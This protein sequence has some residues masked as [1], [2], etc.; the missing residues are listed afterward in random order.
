MRRLSILTFTL[1][2]AGCATS[3]E[4]VRS[5]EGHPVILSGTLSGAVCKAFYKRGPGA[6]KWEAELRRKI[7]RTPA[8]PNMRFSRDACPVRG[9]VAQCQERRPGGF[10]LN[11]LYNAAI[12]SQFRAT[13]LARGHEYRAL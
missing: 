10:A 8:G 11:T 13:C 12:R 9:A 7:M 1:F 4:P 5:I 3:P 6:Q 2:L